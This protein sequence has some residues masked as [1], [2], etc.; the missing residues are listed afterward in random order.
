MTPYMEM[1]LMAEAA[2][3]NRLEVQSK[4]DRVTAER[5]AALVVNEQYRGQITRQALTYRAMQQ[6]LTAADELNDTTKAELAWQESDNAELR[7]RAD[8]LLVMLRMAWV[9]TEVSAENC[10]RID[11]ALKLAEGGGDDRHKGCCCPPK[12]H[13]GL[14]AGAS[15]PIHQGLRAIKP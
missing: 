7:K 2:E 11:A 13:T 12:G 4:L 10:R 1:K 5:D 14:W 8:E 15:C 6:R 9:D 3:S